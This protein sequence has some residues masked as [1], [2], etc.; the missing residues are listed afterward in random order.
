MKNSS[1]L[2][3]KTIYIHHLKMDWFG[4]WLQLQQM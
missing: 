4:Y 2:T 3:G 1:Y